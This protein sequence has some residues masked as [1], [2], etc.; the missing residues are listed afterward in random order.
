M[1]VKI[2][3]GMEFPQSQTILKGYTLLG[4]NNIGVLLILVVLIASLVP[5]NDIIFITEIV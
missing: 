5:K 4:E 2:F 1:R 3:F